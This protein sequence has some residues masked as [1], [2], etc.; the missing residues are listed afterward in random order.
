MIWARKCQYLGWSEIPDLLQ[1]VFALL[2]DLFFLP[3]RTALG[4]FHFSR[5]ENKLKTSQMLHK[6][7]P[8]P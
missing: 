7:T 3:G 1:L 2:L 5:Q 8:Q 4:K 6:K